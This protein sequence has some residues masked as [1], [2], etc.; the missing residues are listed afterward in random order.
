M[1]FILDAL[2]KSETER[3]RQD[4]PGIA[5][6][7]DATRQNPPAR[8]PWI[9][10]GLLTVNLVVLAAIVLRPEPTAAPQQDVASPPPA[11]AS[12]QDPA[13]AATQPAPSTSLPAQQT[14]AN[15]MTGNSGATGSSSPVAQPAIESQPVA[16]PP[17]PTMAAGLPTLRD[18]VAAGQMQLPDMHLDIHVYSGQPSDRFRVRQHAEIHGRCDPDRRAQCHGD[19][20]GGRGSRLLRNAIPVAPRIGRTPPIP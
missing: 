15:V 8:W 1:S 5:S 3:K 14:P 17:P 16:A 4:A 13:P 6:I 11:I 12:A 10:A 20:P 9:V 18:L 2:K 19:H 7:P